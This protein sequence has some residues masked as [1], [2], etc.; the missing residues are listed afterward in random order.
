MDNSESPKRYVS[1]VLRTCGVHGE[2][3]SMLVRGAW[4]G[5]V[6]CD[7]AAERDSLAGENATWRKE[8]RAREWNAKLGRA[9]IPDRFADRRLATYEP[10]CEAAARA[11]G[12]ATAYAEN[13]DEARAK[14]KC[15]IFCGD[16]GTGKTHLAIGIAH[17][18]LEQGR[19][20]VF[21]SVIRAVR[22]VKETY[23]KGA[24]RTEAQALRDLVEPD[25][26]ILDEVGVQFGSDTEKL[27][28]F[29][30]INGRYEASRPTIVISNLAVDA[31]EA[32][33]GTRSFDRLREGGGRLVVF[34]WTSYRARRAA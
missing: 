7:L 4:S 14:G 30:V 8:L 33:L 23:A 27:I 9:A 25:L 10:A 2:Y 29:E 1:A 20:A 24:G 17:A 31:L 6:S 16:V 19:Q 12:V 3:T 28:L 13:F 11:L 15:L 32:Y 22:S 21:T 5:C 34:D 18:V 26:L